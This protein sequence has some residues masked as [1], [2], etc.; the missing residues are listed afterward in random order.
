MKSLLRLISFLF[1][2]T[3]TSSTLINDTRLHIR[4][5]NNDTR[6]RLDE[7]LYGERQPL[8]SRGLDIRSLDDIKSYMTASPMKIYA[9]FREIEGGAKVDFRLMG[10][11]K[12]KSQ[13]LASIFFENENPQ[14]HKG[15]ELTKSIL[16]P[17]INSKSELGESYWSN[18]FPSKPIWLFFLAGMPGYQFSVY[19]HRNWDKSLLKKDAAEFFKEE[20]K[21]VFGVPVSLSTTDDAFSK[22]GEAYCQVD[23]EDS[24]DI[25]VC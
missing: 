25:F 19:W 20:V 7:L 21:K 13:D 10:G 11:L 22:G 4:N 9:T 1:I 16:G 5:G 24:P 8:L 2:A 18:P 17:V 3:L 6:T 12:F 15:I 23:D 14:Y